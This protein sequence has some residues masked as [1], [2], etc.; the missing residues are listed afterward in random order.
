MQDIGDKYIQSPSPELY[1]LT[2]DPGES[3]NLLDQQKSKS[4]QLNQKLVL[5]QSKYKN[6]AKVAEERTVSAD[7][8]EQFAAI[9]YLGGQIPETAWDRSKD[10]KDYLKDWN[11][12]LEATYLVGQSKY[13]QAL[14]LIEK[15]KVRLPGNGKEVPPSIS[16]L[17]SKCYMGMGDF[18]KAE[19]VLDVHKDSPEILTARADLYARSGQPDQASRLY[20]EALDRQFSYF[21]LYNYALF[22]KKSGKKDEALAYVKQT[23]QSRSDTEEATPFLAETYFMLGDAD[24]AEQLLIR[25][26][27]QRPWEAKWYVELASVLQAR[28]RV[29]EAIQLLRNNYTRFSNQGDYLMRLGILYKLAGNPA[30]ELEAFKQMVRANPGDPRGYYYL[31]KAMLDQKQDPSTAIQV[32]IR[33]FQCNPDLQMQIFGHYVLADAYRQAGK[34][35]E[36]DQEMVMAKK[37][38]KNFSGS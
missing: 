25:L 8:A 6:S 31:A 28:G 38:E 21:V 15:I 37:L 24:Q 16:L 5:Y 34:Q 36:A 3:K 26:I 1:D 19:S 11:Q 13:E 27:K 23:Q 20:R 30:G 4:Q 33:G 12:L 32:A 7:Q 22:L 10:P 2:S 29:P 35:K 9:G 14:S 18:K 17:E